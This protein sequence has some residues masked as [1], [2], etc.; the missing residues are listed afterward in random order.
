ML[1]KITP[2]QLVDLLVILHIGKKIVVFTTLF[3]ESPASSRTDFIFFI[4]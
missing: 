1:G 4:T 3:K 2:I